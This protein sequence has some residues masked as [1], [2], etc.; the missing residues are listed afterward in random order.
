MMDSKLP[1]VSRHPTP[2]LS[3]IS[4]TAQGIDDASINELASGFTALHRRCIMEDSTIATF[5]PPLDDNKMRD[6]WL[7][8]I[9]QC[10][11]GTPESGEKVI[12]YLAE[13]GAISGVASLL[14]PW[15]QTGNHR[16]W[17]EKLMVDGR[18]RQR[19]I[20]R[21][22]MDELERIAV[23]KGKWILLLDTE[24]GSKAEKVYPKLG[25]VEYGTIPDYSLTM[26]S[27]VLPHLRTGW[28]VDQAI[29]NEDERLVVIR[30]GR[31]YSQDCMRQDEVLFKIADRVKNFAVIYVCDLEEV[32]DFKQMYELYDPMTIM[33]FFRNK[34]MMCD[35]GTGNNNK[36]NWVLED[37]QELIDIVETIY[38]GAK[39][40]R[41]L[42]SGKRQALIPDNQGQSTPSYPAVH[43]LPADLSTAMSCHFQPYGASCA[44]D[45]NLSQRGYESFDPYNTSYYSNAHRSHGDGS[46]SHSNIHQFYGDETN[47]HSNAYQS[48]GNDA[49][50]QTNAYHSF[51]DGA[52][53]YEHPSFGQDFDGSAQSP[54]SS[55][56]HSYGYP[57]QYEPYASPYPTPPG[58]YAEQYSCGYQDF[59]SCGGGCCRDDMPS[60]GYYMPGYYE[61]LW[62]PVMVETV[63][64]VEEFTM[65]RETRPMARSK[66][67]GPRKRAGGRR[68]REY[69]GSY[70]MG[71][72]G[73]M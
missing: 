65:K 63:E 5:L 8:L 68:G 2:P 73:M 42:V 33:F 38:R 67:R 11:S 16:A 59:D 47:F 52:G 1:A 23:E 71:G 36:L 17:V 40:G 48:F 51:G 41:G 55:Y 49:N 57:Q 26:G 28:H 54:Y 35:F 20:A 14:L 58:Q 10:R 21:R 32:P 18:L 12:V 72:C 37:K 43:W 3:V 64:N 25:Y 7:G 13:D 66:T 62:P 39:K 69:Y 30:F 34:H 53:T 61:Y 9:Q 27:V 24:T 22:L 29:M 50:Y 31:D 44:C 56:G 19:G 46:D 6:F 45:P 4:S 70:G 15:S 60:T